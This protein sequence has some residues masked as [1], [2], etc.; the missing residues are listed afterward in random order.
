MTQSSAAGAA[1]NCTVGVGR[2]QAASAIIRGMPTVTTTTLITCVSEPLSGAAV[3]LL[4]VPWFEDPGSAVPGL[5]AATGGEIGRALAT[6]ELQAK[7]FEL[8]VTPI[9]DRQWRARRVALIGAGRRDTCTGDLIR[10]LAAA[11]GLSARQRRTATAAF[12][13]LGQG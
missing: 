1:L 3:D 5:D 4:V 13:L 11:S 12:A 2:G 9:I 10:K 7:P 6:K 8:F